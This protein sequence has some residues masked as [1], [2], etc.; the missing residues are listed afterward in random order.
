MPP[1]ATF[2]TA[3]LALAGSLSALPEPPPALIPI[4]RRAEWKD[5][6]ASPQ[7]RLVERHDPTLPP[8]G[9]RLEIAPDTI[10][11]SAS[12]P[13]GRFYAG[14]T[15]E[16]LRRGGACPQGIVEDAPRFPWRGVLIDDSR[17]FAGVDEIKKILHLMADYKLNVL[18]WHLTDSEGWRIEIP[19]YPKLASQAAAAT[20][21]Y[22][23][24]HQ[25]GDG[26][27]G[28]YCYTR[29]QI[30]QIVECAKSLHI[31]IVPEVDF[32][33]HCWALL[34]AYPELDC[35]TPITKEYQ[36]GYDA[37][38]AGNPKTIPFLKQIF[39][40]VCNLFPDSDYVH[41]GGDEVNTEKWVLCERCRAEA[42][43]KGYGTKVGLLRGDLLREIETFLAGRGKRAI[44]WDEIL[45]ANVRQSCAI[46]SWTGVSGGIRAAADGHR[47][48]MTPQDYCYLDFWQGCDLDPYTYVPWSYHK[49]PLTLEKCYS[50]DPARGLKPG[51]EQAILGIQGNN[52]RE[53]T[54]TN[55]ALEWKMFPRILAI[56]EI[57]WSEQKR[58]EWPDFLR[59][60]R[61]EIPVL[62]TKGVNVCPLE[63]PSV[64][65]TGKE[66]Q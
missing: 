14:R 25:Q 55:P 4:P 22:R 52:W 17:H 6:L 51:T 57:G 27:Y 23:R 40:E 65:A 9:Y 35:T 24:A 10:T 63:I 53:V 62:Q 2:L 46:M 5:A 13:A 12:T 42:E 11:I 33:G 50:Y 20:G 43:K 21:G 7:A 66:P 8:E 41:I 34:K 48:V 60:V 61:A 1:K 39:Q 28:P 36:R 16:Q 30:R 29:E 47:V 54:Y 45:G 44:G 31:R 56:A 18:H 58:R 38:C 26:L 3:C 19:A 64:L 37:I 15:L 59:R 49:N 32:P